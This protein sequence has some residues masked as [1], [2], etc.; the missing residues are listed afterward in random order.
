MSKNNSEPP[1]PLPAYQ[2]SDHRFQN[3]VEQS[4]DGIIIVDYEGAIRYVNPAIERLFGLEAKTL[5]G[6][7]FGFPL[8]VGE[9]IEVDINQKDGSTAIA[10]MRIVETEWEGELAFLATVRNITGRVQVAEQLLDNVRES[11]VATNLEGLIIHWNKGAEALYGYHAREVLG[12]PVTF[13]FGSDYNHKLNQ[14]GAGEIWS[15]ESK[16]KRRDGT[17][18]WADS[19]I[20]V[21]K[22][23]M[24]RPCG[25]VAIDRDTTERRQMEAIL[26]QHNYELLLL[27]QASQR[28]NATL[29]LDEVLSAVLEE[30]GQLLNIEICSVWLVN[31]RTN[32][33]VCRQAIGPK[34]ELVCGWRVQRGEGLV[35]WVAEHGES[36][37]V[38]DTEKEPRHYRLVNQKTGLSMRSI[39]SVPL[40]A[41]SQEIIGVIQVMDPQVNRF[42]QTDKIQLEL[43]ASTASI[44]IANARLYEQTRRDAETKAALFNEVNHRVKNNL[45]ALIGL[46]YAEQRRTGI[47]DTPQYQALLKELTN[48]IQGLAAAHRLLSASEWSPLPLSELALQVIHSALQM[49]PPDKQVYVKVS[50][51]PFLVTPK[52][53]NGLALVINEL[54]TNT[55]KY[56][57]TNQQVAHFNVSI[58]VEDKTATVE[59]RDDGPG[60]PEKILQGD[61]Y[62]VGLYIV[63]TI[64]RDDL[65]GELIINNNQG[66]VTKICF[67]TT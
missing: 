55:I 31:S 17:V 18:F 8:V 20:S 54:T 16:L 62:N 52:Q 11:V 48:R 29:K 25:W 67:T 19:N 66:A 64:V 53:A 32:E 27:N 14:I 35:G 51:S 50:P 22:D 40:R 15:G 5:I 1:N 2:A 36:L 38:A 33:L 61:G 4:A 65:Q 7:V 43:L 9:T 10:E 3:I 30:T 49:L 23:Q 37:F 60:Y 34:A 28:L 57:L 26:Q 12:K 58:M 56:A 21:V 63:Q 46:L 13:I 39:L 41:S 59:F 44:A 24:G 6:E 47:G 42:N 45:S